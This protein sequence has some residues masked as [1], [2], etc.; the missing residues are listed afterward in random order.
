M[1]RTQKKTTMVSNEFGCSRERQVEA[2]VNFTN[3]LRAAFALIF[4]RQKSANLKSKFKK[5]APKSF[6]QKSHA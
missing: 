1:R 2:E 3:F 6:P 5:A 4:L